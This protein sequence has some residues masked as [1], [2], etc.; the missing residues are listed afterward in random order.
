LDL[1]RHAA[2]DALKHGATARQHDVL[3]Q[4]LLDV[5]VALHDRVV[6]VFVDAVLAQAHRRRREQQ[7]GALQPLFADR[8]VVAGRQAVLALGVTIHFVGVLHLCVE[9][10]GDLACLDLD[11]FAL[12]HVVRRHGDD[13]GVLGVQHLMHVVGEVVAANGDFARRK[14]DRVALVN[15][16]CVGDALTAVQHRAGRLAVSE[17]RQHRLVPEVELGHVE[18]IKPETDK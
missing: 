7:L 16:H 17:E 12:A 8:H 18:L 15:G 2:L 4:V 13:V 9:V 3:E 5:G 14:G 10:N 6:R 11:L 1:F